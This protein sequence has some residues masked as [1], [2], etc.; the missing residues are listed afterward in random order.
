MPSVDFSSVGTWIERGPRPIENGSA[1]TEGSVFNDPVS[2]AVEALAPHPTN[3]NIL[4]A[5]TVNG[6]VWMT[7][8]AY[9]GD[10][11]WVPLTDQFPSLSIGALAFSPLDSN[12]KTLFAGIGNTS[13]ADRSGGTLTGPHLL[14]TTNGGV[15]WTA[16][17]EAAPPKIDPL[18]GLTL[19]SVVPT[20]LGGDVDHQ[21]VLLAAHSWSR[22]TPS[23][24]LH[25]GVYRSLN[26]GKDIEPTP[27][28]PGAA[29]QVVAAGA[30]AGP[31]VFYAG[32]AGQGVFRSMPGT[33][34]AAW[35]K[36]NTGLNNVAD[37]IRIEFAVFNKDILFVALVGS[38]GELSG[39]YSSPDGGNQ[40]TAMGDS[41]L[42]E[43]DPPHIHPRGQGRINL[44][45]TVNPQ[46]PDD[47]Y[48][49]GD[50]GEFLGIDNDAVGHIEE[51]DGDWDQ[52]TGLDDGPHPGSRDMIFDAGG[53]LLEADD[54]GIYRRVDHDDWFSVIGNLGNTE[55]TSIS[56][57]AIN[58]KVFA[59][60]QADSR[61]EELV[62][63][64]S[65]RVWD[66]WGSGVSGTV[67]IGYVTEDGVRK[68]VRYGMGNKI[69]EGGIERHEYTAGNNQ[70][71]D[72][73]S[74]ADN[75]DSVDSLFGRVVRSSRQFPL[76]VNAIEGFGDRIMIG[77]HS[78]Y[79]SLDNGDTLINLIPGIGG[80]QGNVSA[81]AYGGKSFGEELPQVFVA[82]MSH[83]TEI[84]TGSWLF[85]RGEQSSRVNPIEGVLDVFGGYPP[86]SGPFAVTKI[87]MDPDNWKSVYV[88][89]GKQIFYTHDITSHLSLDWQEI[90]GNLNDPR[91]HVGTI[92]T[93]EVVR[94]SSHFQ[95]DVLL[96]GADG[97][98]FAC[99]DPHAGATTWHEVGA[100]LPN[101][102]VTDLHYIPSG[103]SKTST[104]TDDVLVAGTLGRGAWLL[105][106][107]LKLLSNPAVL[108]IVGDTSPTKLNDTIRLGADAANKPML[109]VSLNSTGKSLPLAA[110]E[111]IFISGRKGQDKVTFDFPDGAIP[112]I[113]IGVD[114]D[115]GD[116]F[117]TL[118]FTG[119][120]PSPIDYQ[121]DA[122]QSLVNGKLDLL[123]LLSFHFSNVQTV[124]NVAPQIASVQLDKSSIV[125][126]DQVTVSGTFIDPGV[127]AGHSVVID[128]GRTVT[129][130]PLTGLLPGKAGAVRFFSVTHAVDGGGNNFSIRVNVVDS[131]NL[132]SSTE[133]APISV[134]IPPVAAK[135]IA[136]IPMV[137]GA[138]DP[139]TVA[140]FTDPDGPDVSP[141]I[142]VLGGPPQSARPNYSARI[143][144][145][146]GSSPTV[147]SI[148]LP[149]GRLVKNT[150]FAVMGGHAYTTNGSF[151]VTVTI[152][153]A[154]VIS[155]ATSTAVVD[156]ILGPN[157]KTKGTLI[158]GASLAGDV[159]Q[160]KIVGGKVSVVD[161]GTTLGTFSGVT[162]IEMY[163]QV[164][165]DRLVVDAGVPMPV[166]LI[167]NQ[168]NDTLAGGKNYD[169]LFG[170]DG[171]DLL[172]G[173]NGNDTLLG[174]NG[175][176]TLLG[177][178]GNDKM[179][180]G[181]GV[182][183]LDGGAG[184]DGIVITGTAGDDH[185]T[186]GRQ[187]G[188]DGAQ[189]VVEMNGDV[190]VQDYVHG[191]TIFVFAGD[192][193]DV[194]RMLP[195]AADNWRAEFHGEAGD[196]VLVG[197]NLGDILDGGSGRNVLIGGRGADVLKAGDGD[198]LVAGY[199]AFDDNDAALSAIALEWSSDRNYEDRV[200]NLRGQ[201]TDDR[202]NGDYFLMPDCA[203]P[204]VFED[205]DRDVLYG[206]PG[207]DWLFANPKHASDRLVRRHRDELVAEL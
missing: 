173:N 124:T 166:V 78:L 129:T 76:A 7:T 144:W 8:N 113:P 110:V 79:E 206:G 183:Q 177:G 14:R 190:A 54:G 197:G 204:T 176:D 172:V 195:S 186:I 68:A 1:G 115:G 64:H 161:N 180:G 128:W 74:D 75:L 5:G 120:V 91:L 170:G 58:D 193:N 39:V 140:T 119:Q 122:D 32:I 164:G 118:A 46:N 20:R 31:D 30:G 98:V 67:G 139:V 17:G 192:G 47:V 97:G 13:S 185:I 48:I 34:G 10:P 153:H 25:G 154:G 123:G 104:P 77:G 189:A 71:N 89:N 82:C 36:I 94:K 87:V 88:T 196:D 52:I 111:R 107:A 99:R 117:N 109:N 114:Y 145:G 127:L 50:I 65:T 131:E 156:S 130:T 92:R 178:N 141:S 143:D 199:T 26:G 151:P 137:R 35:E 155:Q 132:R 135:G 72:E 200:A 179:E 60:A 188:P 56:Y 95:D 12:H 191:E 162:R 146:D 103:T 22:D 184:L 167:G 43:N 40:W 165:D 174:G 126:G 116:G 69:N 9:A 33:K 59:G 202:A 102:P 29:T 4:Y 96:V 70:V 150:A 105:K 66:S 23:D 121:P 142:A 27:V 181:A 136:S 11:T 108:S 133:E 24:F 158:V 112:F 205:G 175:N 61:I 49:G 90:T 194:V 160:A 53:N 168:G 171:N 73:D 85:Y 101:A 37:S 207:R 86:F 93:L 149:S 38:D 3:K 100:N 201:G 80:D 203:Q 51:W 6:G 152:N 42:G 138:T 182:N 125:E 2:G 62:P 84:E 57:D 83:D 15:T 21:V 159:I 41:G 55:I 18:A 106:G 19:E 148:P 81:I 187:V 16:L 44:S 63:D 163:G 169:V 45:L 157:P 28:L 134:T 147:A 198:L